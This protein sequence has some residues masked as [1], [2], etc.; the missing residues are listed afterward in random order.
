MSLAPELYLA[1]ELFSNV[2]KVLETVALV[3]ISGILAAAWT[4]SDYQSKTAALSLHCI[5]S[6]QLA[7]VVCL[8]FTNALTSRR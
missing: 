6:G 7:C 1:S 8:A 5:S 2:K 3:Y 4:K